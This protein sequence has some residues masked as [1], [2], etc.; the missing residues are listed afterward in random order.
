MRYLFGPFAVDTEQRSLRRDEQCVS[1]APKA[2]DLLVALL[3]R[4]GEVIE[5]DELLNR[6]WPDQVVEEGNL[7]VNISSLRKVLGE[8]AGQQRYIVTVPSRGYKFAALVK[9][10]LP[11]R[12]QATRAFG[13]GADRRQPKPPR[14]ANICPRAGSRFGGCGVSVPVVELRQALAVCHRRRGDPFCRCAP[15]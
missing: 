7:T 3:E 10:R 5:K 15:V 13:T 6:V 12:S 14:A 4:P 11:K 2:F 8:Q 1:V 9:A